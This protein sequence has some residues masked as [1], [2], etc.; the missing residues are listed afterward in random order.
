MHTNTLSKIETINQQVEGQRQQEPQAPPV[1]DSVQFP[2]VVIQYALNHNEDGDAFLY[3]EMN[4]GLFC[5]DTAAGR[6]YVWTGHFWQKDILGDATKAIDGIIE[7]YIKEALRVS[8]QRLHA[9]RTGG[10]QGEIKRL[11]DLHRDLCNRVRSLQTVKRKTNVLTLS[12]TGADSLAIRGDEWDRDPWLLGCRNGV[13]DLRTGELMPGQPSD[14]I[15][16]IAPTEYHGLHYPAPIWEQFILDIFQYDKELAAYIQR[17]LGYG[18]TGHS[19]W[20]VYPIF[21]GQQGRNGK[22]TIL[23]T[24]KT[25]LGDLAHKAR[26]DTLLESGKAT[27]GSADADT[28][29]FRGKRIIWA[30]ETSEGRKLNASRIKE[31]CGGDTLNARAVYGRDPV[32]FSPTHLLILLTNDRPQAPA[33]DEALWERINLIPFNVRFVDNPWEKNE[34]PADHDLLE[35]LKGE[36]S[37][38]L[39]WLVRGCL[40]WQREG[41]KPPETVL[42]ATKEYRVGEDM[43][44]QFLSDRCLTGTDHKA[45]AGPLYTAYLVWSSEMGIEPMKG[46]RF[47]KEIASRFEKDESGR[48]VFYLGIGL[49]E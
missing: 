39:S 40:A 32:E 1:P 23:E 24:L 48:H 3:Q 44:E 19:N 18:I 14:Y 35:K 31:L 45:Q 29:A 37:G 8:W 22:G 46:I 2:S 20:H 15:K 47:A 17:L 36:A 10:E 38:I 27:R 6:W 7:L 43:I 41:L 49:R 21:H 4:R 13:I 30:S 5:Y 11:N 16:T 33:G 28:L 9:L 26:S 25:V 42:V 34:R 12:H